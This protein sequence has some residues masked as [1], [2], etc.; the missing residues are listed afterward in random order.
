MKRNRPLT[1]LGI[2]L[3]H[4][5]NRRDLSSKEFANVIQTTPQNLSDIL[6]GDRFSPKTLHRWRARFEN[7]LAS[8]DENRG[9]DRSANIVYQAICTKVTVEDSSYIVYGMQMLRGTVGHYLI[10]DEIQDITPNAD[11]ILQM[12]QLF[13]CEK[14]AEVHFRDVV[15]DSVNS[16]AY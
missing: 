11:R 2:W 8:I 9:A 7:A 16:F 3:M 13:N 10:A 14:V 6:R 4:E 1:D 15:M 5:L 12:V